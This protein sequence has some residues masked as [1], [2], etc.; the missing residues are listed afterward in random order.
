MIWTVW[1]LIVLAG[2]WLVAKIEE[3]MERAEE[4]KRNEE[5]HR[6]L[7]ADI[8]SGLNGLDSDNTGEGG[9]SE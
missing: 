3:L 5:I 9:Q 1:L 2:V 8:I 4:K 6:M 7:I